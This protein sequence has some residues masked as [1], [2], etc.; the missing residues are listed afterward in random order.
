MGKATDRGCRGEGA[1]S[2]Y[3]LLYF[4]YF[5]LDEI[6]QQ[7]VINGSCIKAGRLEADSFSMRHSSCGSRGGEGDRSVLRKTGR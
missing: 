4:Y 6:F 3:L 2:V 1:L 7:R 5:V